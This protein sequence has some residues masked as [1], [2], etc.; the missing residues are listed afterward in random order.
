M[1]ASLVLGGLDLHSIGFGIE[2]AQL[3]P[4]QRFGERLDVGVGGNCAAGR[5]VQDVGQQ[6]GVRGHVSRVA[7]QEGDARGH[8]ERQHQ[9]VA[10]GEL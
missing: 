9:A 8:H 3:G 5:D 7:L 6:L 2:D 1:V 4:A 10:L